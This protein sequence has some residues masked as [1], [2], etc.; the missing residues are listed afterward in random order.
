M[1]PIF[2]VLHPIY[3]KALH[4]L[5]LSPHYRE[6]YDFTWV[7]KT[8]KGSS[9]HDDQPFTERMLGLG[10]G[11]NLLNNEDLIQMFH[12]SSIKVPY[13]YGNFNQWGT[14]QDWDVCPG[15]NS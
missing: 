8:C 12:P 9:L 13:M 15:C 2:W 3:E 10:P 14:C 1:D 11:T 5:M 4:V 7:N 6:A